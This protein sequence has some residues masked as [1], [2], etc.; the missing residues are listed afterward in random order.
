MS[1]CTTT[2]DLRNLL[3]LLFNL[4]YII[5]HC[6]NVTASSPAWL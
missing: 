4:F 6:D 3:I 5:L 1:I 2:T